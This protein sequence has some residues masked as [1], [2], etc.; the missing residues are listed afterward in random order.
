MG[1]RREVGSEI[2][3]DT[4]LDQ[5][6]QT[7]EGLLLVPPTQNTKPSA[8]TGLLQ[9]D[10]WPTP[11]W[12]SESDAV[13]HMKIYDRQFLFQ[14]RTRYMEIETDFRSVLGNAPDTVNVIVDV[15]TATRIVELLHTSRKGLEV[16][17]IDLSVI[18]NLLDLAERLMVWLYPEWI[19]R[20]KMEGLLLKL[21]SIPFEQKNALKD[22]ILRLSKSE[23]ES[24]PGEIRSV[25][26]DAIGIF[27]SK[28]VE[29]RVGRGLQLSRLRA[30]TLWGVFILVLFL[31]VT[32]ISLR[33]AD[34]NAWPSSIVFSNT[35]FAFLVWMNGIAVM[36]FGAMGGF[37]S[38]LLHARSTRIT[39]IEYF[40][41]MVKLLLRPL[42][43]SLVAL[44]L[45]TILSW[46][47]LPGIDI[48]NPG[49]YFLVAFLSGFSERYFLRML[50]TEPE[51]TDEQITNK[52]P[53]RG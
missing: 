23:R 12:C 28:M 52:I 36:S 51:G 2:S 21:D 30:L 8:I 27:N 6:D 39:L 34:V 5:T 29:D 40:E 18:S 10:S 13:K 44:V 20:A 45:Y 26:D 24:Y 32:P 38:G 49:S 33:V 48:V 37:L 53:Q 35:S 42:V 50:K 46:K 43:G 19:A 17:N 1:L 47:V 25:L 16:S 4:G 14:L 22:R 41:S 31:A 3:A 9:P 15:V 11:K 7:D